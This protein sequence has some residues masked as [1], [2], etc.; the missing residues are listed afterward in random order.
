MIV[1]LL[2]VRPR[3]PAVAVA[4]EA[5]AD[6]RR[7]AVAVRV[8]G[9]YNVHIYIYTYIHRCVWICMY[10]YIYIYIHVSIISI[11]IIIIIIGSH[12]H[13]GAEPFARRAVA[14]LGVRVIVFLFIMFDD[15]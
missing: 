1:K 2:P 11:I 15:S 8:L 4:G 14:S 9:S 5:A 3:D 12:S 6:E 7:E 10:I 13:G